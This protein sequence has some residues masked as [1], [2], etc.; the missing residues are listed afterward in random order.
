MQRTV[1][2]P[3]ASPDGQYL[4]FTC[5]SYGTF[6]LWHNDAKIYL[7][8]LKTENTDTLPELNNNINYANSYHSWSTNSHWLAFASKRDNGLYSKI[9]FS[10]IDENGHAHKPF[11]LP[12]KDPEYYNFLL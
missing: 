7:Y 9:Y 11:V 4:A 12:Q 5:F 10:Y 1:S 6:P 2:Q 3:K 8:N